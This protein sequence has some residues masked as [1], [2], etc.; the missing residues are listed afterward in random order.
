MH[1]NCYKNWFASYEPAYLN[2]YLI[3]DPVWNVVGHDQV[4]LVDFVVDLKSNLEK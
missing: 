3:D 2:Y 1:W 4:Q